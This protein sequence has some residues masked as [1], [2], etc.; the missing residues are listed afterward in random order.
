MKPRFLVVLMALTVAVAARSQ[1][2]SLTVVGIVVNEADG[3]VL[4]LCNVQ[5][6]QE[7]HSV[8]SPGTDR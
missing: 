1:A 6:F 7:G 5:L 4:P 3:K 2:D 8:A